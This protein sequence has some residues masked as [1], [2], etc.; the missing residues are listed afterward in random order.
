M[1]RPKVPISIISS[2]NIVNKYNKMGWCLL[3]TSKTMVIIKIKRNKMV[4][5]DL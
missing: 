4:E 1:N 3:I 5:Q 2:S